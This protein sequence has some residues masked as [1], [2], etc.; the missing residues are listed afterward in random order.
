VGRAPRGQGADAGP[1]RR[2]EIKARWRR[3]LSVLLLI[4]RVCLEVGVPAA[5]DRGGA[6]GPG[7][8]GPARTP[9]RTGHCPC[10]GFGRAAPGGAGGRRGRGLLPWGC[11]AARTGEDTCER[12]KVTLGAHVHGGSRALRPTPS[13]RRWGCHL[14]L[15]DLPLLPKA[16]HTCL[17]CFKGSRGTSAP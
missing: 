1:P 8:G 3:D 15:G 11:A 7:S 12:P 13:S 14:R 16:V 10:A 4:S 2:E 6:R 5:R 9:R 17:N